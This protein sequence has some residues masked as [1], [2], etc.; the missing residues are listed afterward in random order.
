LSKK[1]K[2]NFKKLKRKRKKMIRGKE[3]RIQIRKEKK[4]TKPKK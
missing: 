4:R 2:K 1:K 3:W